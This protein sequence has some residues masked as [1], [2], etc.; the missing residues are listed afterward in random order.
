MLTCIIN[1]Q[2]GIYTYPFFQEHLIP[3]CLEVQGT[4]NVIHSHWM[5]EGRTPQNVQCRSGQCLPFFPSSRL[6]EETVSN[7]HFPTPEPNKK[8]KQRVSAVPGSPVQLCRSSPSCL[9]GTPG[10]GWESSEAK[11]AQKDMLAW[12]FFNRLKRIKSVL[13]LCL[14]TKQV[15]A[16]I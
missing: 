14:I 6:L 5:A 4:G 8:E 2:G 12:T 15:H 3:Y 16:F 10:V 11:L 7:F 9:S 1:L 13:A